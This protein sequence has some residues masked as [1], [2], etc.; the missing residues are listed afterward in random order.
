MGTSPPV[1]QEF[2]DGEQYSEGSIQAY[3]TVYGR[4]FVSPGGEPVA[5]EL[6]QRLDLITGSR[7]LDAGCG[8]GGSA[9]LMAR[10]FGWRVDAIDLS[11]NMIAI[12]RQRCSRHGL[13]DLVTLEQGD[14]LELDRRDRYDAIYSRDVFLHIHDKARLFNR[15]FNA[16]RPGG[17]LLFT[18]YC[19]GEKPWRDE[20]T[21]YVKER[22][23]C[24]H[25]LPESVTL[26]Q[27]AGFID[28]EAHDLTTRFV[29]ILETE[30]STIR[31]ANL[32]DPVR[33]KLETGWQAKLQRAGTGDQRWGL[34]AARRP[35]G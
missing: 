30:L 15:L 14:C 16:L 31:A 9:F 1:T 21:E 19:C 20:F 18:D 34:L 27:S 13:D 35:S 26:L 24:L 7:V 25:T 3:E 32:D 23:Y 22:V 11:R 5:R 29:E 33:T 4:D 2:L 10:E 8:L 17:R 6:L 28:V 12:A